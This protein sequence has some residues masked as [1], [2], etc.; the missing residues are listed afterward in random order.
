[1]KKR[2]GV[3]WC[4]VG[5]LQLRAPQEQILFRLQIILRT[6]LFKSYRNCNNFLSKTAYS[7]SY[8]W[9]QPWLRRFVFSFIVR[10]PGFDSKAINLE[11]LVEELTNLFSSCSFSSVCHWRCIVE[12]LTVLMTKVLKLLTLYLSVAFPVRLNPNFLAV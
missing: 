9:R 11:F 4:W 7:L 3:L 8:F 1:V 2:E 12:I 10:R 5:K 6:A